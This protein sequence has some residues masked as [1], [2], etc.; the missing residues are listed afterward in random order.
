MLQSNILAGFFPHENF[1]HQLSHV[2]EQQET[3]K[4][5]VKIRSIKLKRSGA[6]Y[7]LVKINACGKNICRKYHFDIVHTRLVEIGDM[8]TPFL[9]KSQFLFIMWTF[10][11]E[12]TKFTL[13]YIVTFISINGNLTKL[14]KKTKML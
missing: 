12:C 11:F 1:C 13:F 14:Y 9:Q 4:K 2:Q 5:S 6:W 7:R 10:F 8:H 3:T